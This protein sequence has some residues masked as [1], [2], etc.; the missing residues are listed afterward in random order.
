MSRKCLYPF[1]N[2]TVNPSGSATPCCKYNLNRTDTEIDS[3][4]IHDKNIEELFNQ[5]AM[6]RIRQQ[7]LNGEEPTACQACW[8]EESAGVT[9]LRE[10]RNNYLG[11]WNQ[12]RPIY[13]T[14]FDHPEIV[15]LDFKFSSLCN[16]KCRICGPYCSSNWLKESLDTGNYDEHTI[17]FFS[18]YAE[19]KFIDNEENFE[20]FKK[21]LPN[22]HIIEFYGGEPL[23][24]PEHSK[25]MEILET[26]DH[27]SNITLY[28]N[29]N[30][31][32]YDEKNINIWN[33]A[34]L[35]ELNISV[36]DIGDRFEYQRFPAKWDEVLDNLLKFKNN[37]KSHIAQTLYCTISIY[38]IYYIDKL[39]EF[40]FENLGMKIRLNFLHWPDEMSVKQLP[41]NV[42]KKILEKLLNIP[43]EHLKLIDQ[44]TSIE[45]IISF[46]NDSL[47][48]GNIDKLYNTTFKHDQYRNQSFKETFKE[49]WEILNE[50]N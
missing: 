36:D 44:G 4:R 42:R 7:F 45:N 19:R 16:L 3:Y 8:D 46:I 15:T 31:T 5:P 21:I 22:L 23:M 39:L 37:C 33:K 35:V 38:N 32:I 2:L 27:L 25:I 18:K 29:T 28:Y 41:S 49:F 13:E 34:K 20:I 30:G 11:Q 6:E 43:Q 50:K 9:S 47:Q 40:N 10:Y 48:D 12:H 14:K 24:Q 1:T 17:K 26:S